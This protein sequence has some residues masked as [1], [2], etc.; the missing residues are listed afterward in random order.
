MSAELLSELQ[1]YVQK[2]TM[3]IEENEKKEKEQEEEKE[4][5]E[6][7]REENEKKLNELREK[8][9][10]EESKSTT[11]STIS[12]TPLEPCSPLTTPPP[13]PSDS[14][15]CFLEQDDIVEEMIVNEDLTPVPFKGGFL[16][17]DQQY[18]C[19]KDTILHFKIGNG[20]FRGGTIAIVLL[21]SHWEYINTAI[22][23]TSGVDI[24]LFE[25]W[26]N[27][28]SV[29]TV[30]MTIPGLSQQACHVGY[31]LTIPAMD[32][33]PEI[34]VRFNETSSHPRLHGRKP[35]ARAWSFCIFRPGPASYRIGKDSLHSLPIQVVA[36]PRH[37]L[38]TNLKRHG[39]Q[40][41]SIPNKKKKKT[42][43][44]L[45]TQGVL[46]EIIIRLASNLKDGN[47]DQTRLKQLY[48][49][50]VHF[51]EK[52]PII[53]DEVASVLKPYNE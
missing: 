19:R 33:A 53:W 50:V 22:T 5:K 34:F 43:P 4:R 29:K 41:E 46:A 28:C 11:M 17:M 25:L 44:T 39:W 38:G 52:K 48:C 35:E 13:P 30:Q 23:R 6:K 45:T 12:E 21:H 24:P 51:Y 7:E 26:C 49:F 16:E 3:E 40:Y 15:T 1:D 47:L 27:D 37:R 31:V 14:P 18:D 10:R 32:R 36:S 8:L 9:T 2:T 20:E 42:A